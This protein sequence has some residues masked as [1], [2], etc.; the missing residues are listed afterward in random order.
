M[1]DHVRLKH[2]KTLSYDLHTVLYCIM[3]YYVFRPITMHFP[4]RHCFLASVFAAACLGSF[5]FM[6]ATQ[7]WPQKSS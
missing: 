3:M 1:F 2:V 7:D 6:P 4:L 5:F